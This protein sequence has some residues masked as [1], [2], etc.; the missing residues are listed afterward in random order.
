MRVV[1][2]VKDLLADIRTL[3]KDGIVEN[4]TAQVCR[5][6]AGFALFIKCT[7]DTTLRTNSPANLNRLKL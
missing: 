7:A 1:R 4:R 6:I 3:F 5:G 2:G